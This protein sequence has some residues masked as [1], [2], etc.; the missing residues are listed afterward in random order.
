MPGCSSC[1]LYARGRNFDVDQF[2]QRYPLEPDHVWRRA[3]PPILRKRKRRISGFS[4]YI[5]DV[6][7]KASWHA[8]RAVS[9]LCE[10]RS[11]LR[12]LRRTSG[13]NELRLEFCSYRRTEGIQSDL[14]PSGL[15]SLAGSMGIDIE[16]SVYPTKSEYESILGE[17]IPSRPP[18][19]ARRV[20]KRYRARKTPATK[21]LQR[22]GANGS[23]QKANR[24]S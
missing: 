6:D 12:A 4:I 7:R 5:G 1:V 3:D 18:P 20:L 17:K 24:T 16:W 11:A 9:F 21:T 13:V 8:D 19:W 23:A 22:T 2:L 10:W 15:L 14:L